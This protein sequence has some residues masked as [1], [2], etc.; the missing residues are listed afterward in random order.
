[1]NIV[2][3]MR[4]F[5]L[6]DVK[7]LSSCRLLSIQ[8]RFFGRFKVLKSDHFPS[9]SKGQS[10]SRRTHGSDVRSTAHEKSGK[11]VSKVYKKIGNKPQFIGIILLQ[12]FECDILSK[13]HPFGVKCKDC[14]S[15]LQYPVKRYKEINCHQNYE[16]DKHLHY[17][18]EEELR[19]CGQFFR[20]E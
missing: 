1:M 12:F 20:V 8:N 5:L 15:T 16:L 10:T 6:L 17:L 11:K 14:F 9:L 13:I 19:S 3:W 4:S 2:E 18:K 7:P